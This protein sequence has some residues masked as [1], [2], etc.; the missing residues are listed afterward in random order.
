MWKKKRTVTKFK[1][2]CVLQ[3]QFCIPSQNFCV[4]WRNTWC[5]CFFVFFH[6]K[7]CAEMSKYFWATVHMSLG[8]KKEQIIK[9]YF[10]LGLTY[11]DI[12]A[13]TYDPP[14]SSNISLHSQMN[15]K[16][17]K[18]VQHFCGRTQK[19]LRRTE[20]FVGECKSFARECKCFSGVF[21]FV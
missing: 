3:R 21:L 7:T 12:G 15:A 20:S 2:I 19:F 6:F 11:K 13:L 1:Y 16:L 9:L 10:E 14:P 18:R 4:P 17:L 8:G 5:V